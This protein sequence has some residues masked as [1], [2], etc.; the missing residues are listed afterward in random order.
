MVAISRANDAPTS[1]TPIPAPAI[2]WVSIDNP[3]IV[4]PLSISFRP[5]V[6]DRSA[7]MVSRG[8]RPRPSEWRECG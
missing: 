1:D 2:R 8:R 4:V 5:D 6:P 7:S 3:L